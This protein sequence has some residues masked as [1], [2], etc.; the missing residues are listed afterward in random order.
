MAERDARAGDAFSVAL[1]A[2]SADRTLLIAFQLV[3]VISIGVSMHKKRK[4]KKR[5]SYLALTAGHAVGG[6]LA[7]KP[8]TRSGSE[9]ADSYQPVRVR[10]RGGI[11]AWII[12]G[13]IRAAV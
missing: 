4:K 6:R 3:S 11:A 13:E 1:D 12:G 10:E 2:L 9:G 8:Q 7:G 5:S